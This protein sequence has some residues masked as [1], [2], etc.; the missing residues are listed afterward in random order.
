MSDEPVPAFDREVVAAGEGDGRRVEASPAAPDPIPAPEPRPTPPVPVAPPAEP[1]ATAAIGR[2]VPTAAPR[3]DPLAALPTT[4]GRVLSAAFDALTW[5]SVDLRRGGF[6]IG[7]VLFMTV[8]PLVVVIVGIVAHGTPLPDLLE[9]ASIFDLQTKAGEAASQALGATL[10]VVV[11]LAVIGYFVIS[12]EGVAL[13]ILLVGGRLAEKPMPLDA[14]LIRTR[15]VFWRL[16]RAS[17]LVGIPATIAQFA[18]ILPLSSGGQAQEGATL[19]A[20]A[21]S[22]LVVMPFTYY[23]TGIVIGDVNARQGVRRSVTLFRARKRVG[24][25]VAVFAAVAQYLLVFGAGVGGDILTRVIAPLGLSPDGGLVAIVVIGL[26]G[27]VFVFALGSLLFLVAAIGVAPQVVAFLSLTHFTG[28]LDAALADD[29]VAGRRAGR[30]APAVGAVGTP[31]AVGAPFVAAPPAGISVASPVA[32]PVGLP[33]SYLAPAPPPATY[34]QVEPVERPRRFRWITIPLRLGVI[35]GVLSM[36]GGLV[37]L[38]STPPGHPIGPLGVGRAVVE[39]S[40]TRRP[41]TASAPATPDRSARPVDGGRNGL[42]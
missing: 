36:F 28:G 40:I 22:T 8:A 14:A 35:A 30:V 42:R 21:V 34:W 33:P 24:F 27:L 4:S 31:A 3:R 37:Q 5:L 25:T 18:V 23:A 39:P 12:V 2:E 7:A 16:V 19:L 17:I 41:S 11:L 20:T 9:G 10:S 13:S 1:G 32:A 38:A 15:L 29:Q 6:Y 26:L